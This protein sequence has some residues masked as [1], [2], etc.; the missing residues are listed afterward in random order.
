MVPS[1]V[2]FATVPARASIFPAAPAMVPLLI[3]S[4]EAVM[5]IVVPFLAVISPE[6]LKLSIFPVIVLAF[7]V[8]VPSLV[9]S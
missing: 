1:L 2:K 8:I 5:L 6:L 9:K 4:P 3:K 7:A